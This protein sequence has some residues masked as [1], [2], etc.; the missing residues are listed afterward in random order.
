MAYGIIVLRNTLTFNNIN[1]NYGVRSLLLQYQVYVFPVFEKYS[2]DFKVWC[3]Y[4]P[5]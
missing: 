5:L 2:S 3:K 4:K 1:C